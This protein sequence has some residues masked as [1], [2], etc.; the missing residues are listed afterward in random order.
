[1]VERLVAWGIANSAGFV[2]K[3]LLEELARVNLDKYT[4]KFFSE[5]LQYLLSGVQISQQQTLEIA[6]GQ[7]L[8]EFLS[9]VQ[10]ELED[11]DLSEAELKQ[12]VKP[13]QQFIQHEIVLIEL[14]KPFLVDAATNAS[15]LEAIWDELK[16]LPL[17]DNFNWQIL[18]RRYQRKVKAILQDSDE[19]RSILNTQKLEAI[20]RNIKE[21]AAIAP[22]FDLIHYRREI[23][24]AYGHLRLDSF[25]TSGYSYSVKL[26]NM[27]IPQNVREVNETLPQIY[28]LPKEE[29][30]RLKKSNGLEED[31]DIKPEILEQY[32]R[33]YSQQTSRSVLEILELRQT[34]KHIVILGDP[35][36]GKSSLLQYLTQ[37]WAE[38][39]IEDLSSSSIPLLIELRTYM[40][41]RDNHECRDF[42]EFFQQG[43]GF[44][45]F[46]NQQQLDT[47]LKSGKAYVMF[48]GL[49]EVF[50]PNKRE[51]AITDI[52]KFT[53]NYPLVRVLVTSRVIGYKPARLRDAN[54][55]HFMLQDLEPE[56]VQD[57]INRWHDF[58]FSDPL[59]KQRKKERLER[60]IQDFQAIRQL[61]SNPLLLTMM[62]ILNRNQELPRDR[63]ELYNQASRV[64]LQQWDL[65]K[66]LIN[67]ESASIDYKDKQAMLRQVA[68]NM[69]T[70]KKGLSGNLIHKDALESILIKYLQNIGV[71]QEERI[72]QLIIGQLRERN[73][74]LCFL[75]ADYY[76]FVHRTFL[77]YFCAWEFVWQFEKERNIT[78]DSLIDDVFGKHWQDE[79]WHE[80]LRLIAGMID[81]KFVGKIIEYLMNLNGEEEKFINLF[82][83]AKCFSEVRNPLIVQPEAD[84]LFKKIQDLIKY[85][86]PY[87][88][89]YFS[90]EIN[91]VREINTQAVATVA[92]IWKDDPQTKTI[93]Q[94]R[95]QD[96]ERWEVRDAAIQALASNYKDDP[97]TKTILQTRAQDDERWEVRDAAIQ[98]LASNYKDDPQTKTILQT[99]AQDDE[100]WDVR[101]A[102]IQAL[103]SNYKDDPQTITFLQTRAQDDERWD[104]RD[105]AI[106]ALASNYKD[107]P[108]TITIL[109][110]RAQDDE[111]EY[112]RRAAI[113]A[114]ASN[115]KDDP[116]TITIL[117]TRA[118]DDEHGDVRRAAIEALASNYKDD[119]QTITILQTRARDDEDGDVRRAAIEALASNYKD[120][121]QTI[122]ILQT[123]AQDDEDGDVRRAAIE[124]LAS[125]YKDD[126]QT[127]PILQTRAQDD[128]DGDVRR[129]AIQALAK[130]FQYQ[131]DLFNTYHHCA[132]NDPFESKERWQTIP[133]RVAVEIII[134]Q[135]PHHEQTLPLLRDR[136]ENDPDEEVREYA[137][138]KLK[139]WEG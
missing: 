43:S 12:Y 44:V 52:I 105:A 17:S 4:Q 134:K 67:V 100:R 97:Q 77:E 116:Q 38:T 106:Q 117:Q 129:A 37:Q 1:M 87:Y 125:N 138:K 114:L 104:V 32:K 120:D 41:S 46:L 95:A 115:Y 9:L 40:R 62:A 108:Q 133:R 69:Q 35:G 137:Q 66:L 34:Y 61:A 72:A 49:D 128:E 139:Q 99:R 5:T 90:E 96:D 103:A 55:R 126:P 30:E 58:A 86:F 18:T 11:A 36:S 21:I 83:A 93:L 56:Q 6:F 31:V 135:Y 65:E 60:A 88:Y 70:N 132:R 15:S 94:T 47:L 64:L 54:F 53:N 16:L 10:Q 82:L 45:C 107:D 24:K 130:H 121:P 123:R 101:D 33:A 59:D 13:L 113:Q 80:V 7:A 20:Q 29:L 19:L 111:H 112:V 3:T 131:P 39:P 81:A 110:T 22:D 118:Q 91:L 92:A 26:W 79:T 98:A 28:E 48:D 23:Q 89:D 74:I 14:G 27:F 25:D 51:E 42:L 127:I 50:E 76:A 71:H 73:F 75:G 124:A 68:Y 119:P 57:F 122:P 84:K 85:D 8:K 78:I 102:A 136:A 63:S 109:Q 2:F